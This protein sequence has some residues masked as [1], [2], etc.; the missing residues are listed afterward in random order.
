[1]N[2][3][4]FYIATL[5]GIGGLSFATGIAAILG[6]LWGWWVRLLTERWYYIFIL[7]VVIAIFISNCAVATTGG[8]PPTIVIDEFVATSFLAMYSTKK[9]NAVMSLIIF[10]FLDHF[11][12]LGI[13]IVERLPGGFGIV[14]DDIVAMSI[15]IIFISL[16]SKCYGKLENILK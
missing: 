13:H 2:D 14:L 8:D 12:P 11:K 5:V 3:V 6:M 9:A 7:Q 15:A 16:V 10:G 1:M 4:A